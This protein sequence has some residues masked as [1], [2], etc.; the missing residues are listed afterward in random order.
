MNRIQIQI[1]EVF[2]FA[3]KYE[4][5]DKDSGLHT[6][7]IQLLINALGIIAKKGLEQELVNKQ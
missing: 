5:S 1:S 3:K 7:A 2:G 6:N 4:M